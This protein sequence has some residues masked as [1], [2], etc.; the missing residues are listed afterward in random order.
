VI[1]SIAT[2]F[3][4]DLNGRE[5]WAFKEDVHGNFE[6]GTAGIGEPVFTNGVDSLGS[7]TSTDIQFV[8]GGVEQG[9]GY[10]SMDYN[11]ADSCLIP[12]LGNGQQQTARI[13]INLGVWT[14]TDAPFTVTAGEDVQ[15]VELRS[16]YAHLRYEV[17][18]QFTDSI[19]VTIQPNE[20]FSDDYSFFR[21]A[22]VVLDTG[23][24]SSDSAANSDADGIPDEWEALYGLDSALAGDALLDA[25]QDGT[26]NLDEYIAGTD[27]TGPQSYLQLTQLEHADE[28]FT[29]S[30]PSQVGREYSVG[31]K[32]DL[33]A[34]DWTIVTSGIAGTG[35]IIEVEDTATE[36]T[37]FYRLNVT[38]SE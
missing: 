29:L 30:F 22:G 4:I 23:T 36:S 19:D 8:Q 17:R 15:V 35:A 32:F 34:T 33:Q 6:A 13:Y 1:E 28:S 7:A 12:L 37:Q 18:V 31:R 27:P 2:P 14:T 21:V 25:D 11:E 26:S 10:V 3:V 38:L 9:S 16:H 24:T 5:F 20:T